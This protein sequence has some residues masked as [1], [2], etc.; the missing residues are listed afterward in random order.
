MITVTSCVSKKKYLEAVADR[1]R[2]AAE[3]ATSKKEL[4]ACD[5][6]LQ[7]TQSQFQSAKDDLEYWKAHSTNLLERMSQLAV[8]SQSESENVKK[9]L[10]KIDEQDQYIKKL[11]AA[12]QRKDSINLQLVTNLKRS[13]GGFDDNDIQISVKKGVVY[14]SISD[15]LLF[16]T[17]SATVSAEAKTVL[18]KLAQVIN[19]QPSIEV[20]VE[21]HTDTVPIHNEQFADN[22]ALSVARASS[23]IR[24]L[25]EDYKVSPTRMVAAGRGEFSPKATNSTPEGRALNRRTE[26]I[27]VPKIDEFFDLVTP[28]GGEDSRR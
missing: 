21:G 24:I 11:T 12:G 13:L 26:I 16:K 17:G 3:L 20:M 8:L 5:T 6:E 1:D 14:V 9:S 25:E 15:R 18:S 7:L 4:D 28:S 19:T 10:E 27:L 23:I 22:W 2:L